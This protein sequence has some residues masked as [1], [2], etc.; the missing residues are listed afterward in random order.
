MIINILLHSCGLSLGKTLQF[1]SMNRKRNVR[2]GEKL[3]AKMT[4]C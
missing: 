4:I 2:G 1:I 3:L